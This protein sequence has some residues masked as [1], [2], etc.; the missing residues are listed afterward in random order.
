MRKGP[1]FSKRGISSDS[2]VLKRGTPVYHGMW[3]LA[4]TTLSPKRADRGKKCTERTPASR[5]TRS[6]SAQMAVYKDSDQSTKSILLM[7]RTAVGKPRRPARKRCRRVCS[8]TP[9]RASTKTRA[10]SAVEAPVTMLRVYCTWPG[11]SAMMKVRLG[12]EK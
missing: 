7:H 5:A 8:T 9:L 2:R 1:S 4:S 12:V 10:T 11:V 3:V 6:A